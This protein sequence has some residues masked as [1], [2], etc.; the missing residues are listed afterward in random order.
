MIK[1]APMPLSTGKNSFSR[2][3]VKILVDGHPADSPL[4]LLQCEARQC[5]DRSLQRSIWLQINSFSLSPFPSKKPSHI[6]RRVFKRIVTVPPGDYR[7]TFRA[8][9]L[10]DLGLAPQRDIA[11]PRN[12]RLTHTN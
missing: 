6:F 4:L 11:F 10:K 3:T 7:R 8:S 9:L 2:N 5:N 12:S 1:L